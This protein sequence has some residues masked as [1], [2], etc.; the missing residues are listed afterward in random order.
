M[1]N[2]VFDLL[3]T[4]FMAIVVLISLCGLVLIVVVALD[5]LKRDPDMEIHNDQT[6]S[7]PR[8]TTKRGDHEF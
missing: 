4:I 3:L 7:T 5:M 2:P 6:T 1:I 8:T